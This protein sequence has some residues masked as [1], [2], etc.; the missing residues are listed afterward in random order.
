[1]RNVPSLN[2]QAWGGTPLP[3]CTYVRRNSATKIILPPPLRTN[4]VPK[5]IFP[6]YVR[7]SP[8]PTVPGAQITRNREAMPPL[9]PFLPSS[10]T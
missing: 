10:P 5:I 8:T 1:M 2:F 4:R 6:A 9:L 7:L 3:C